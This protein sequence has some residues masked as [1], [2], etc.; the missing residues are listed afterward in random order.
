MQF[1]AISGSLRV[2]STNTALLHALRDAALPPASVTVFDG[3][4]S[5]PLFSPDL[6][7]SA[8]PR[9]VLDFARA[10]AAA[11]S[12]VIACP[13]YARTMPGG[14]KNAIDW[15]VSRDEIVH[16]SIALLHTSHRG[17]EMLGHL[18]RV[19]ETVSTGFAPDV[20]ERIAI[21]HLAPEDRARVLSAP[22]TT[23]RL[24][25]FLARLAASRQH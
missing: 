25:G 15:L 11:D 1:L 14:L 7:G 21:A 13:E 24:R 6:E 3:I 20:F 9:P 10:V 8:T 23:A 12:I 22:E 2:A 5:L 17:D 18:R 19:L 4:R 16:K